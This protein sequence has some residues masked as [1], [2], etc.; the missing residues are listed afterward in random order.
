MEVESSKLEEEA[1]KRREKLKNLR[2]QA[3]NNM[4]SESIIA[5]ELPK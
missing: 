4:D 1:R 2:K 5:E 3:E